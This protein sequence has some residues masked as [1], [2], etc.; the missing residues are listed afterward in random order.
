MSDIEYPHCN[1]EV[2]HAPGVCHYCDQYPDRQKTRAAS[3]TAFTPPQANGWSGNVA[4]KSGELH[5]HLGA[6]F[7]AGLDDVGPYREP[8][9]RAWFGTLLHRLFR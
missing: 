1:S 2:L 5:T 7:I 9:A 3:G 8:A 4:V 6:T